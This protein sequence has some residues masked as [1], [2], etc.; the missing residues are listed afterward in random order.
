MIK[1]LS[2]LRFIFISLIFLHHIP[3]Y[4]GGGTLGVAFFF[5][6]GGFSLT[7]GYFKIVSDRSF[8]FCTYIN[9]RLT[10]FYPLHWLCLIVAIVRSFIGPHCMKFSFFALLPNALLLQ[11]WFPSGE[12]YN[13]YNA[14]SWYLS[15]TV[16]F[17]LI[18][19][20]ILKLIINTTTKQKIFSFIIIVLIYIVLTLV[21]PTDYYIFY[22]F[23]IVR[24]FDFLIGIYLAVTLLS[25]N[26]NYEKS[27]KNF[28]LKYSLMLNF[29]IFIFFITLILISIYSKPSIKIYS[30]I[31]WLPISTLIFLVTLKSKNGP[32]IKIL[33]LPL[34]VKLG[35]SSFSFY[36]IHQL[37]ISIGTMVFRYLNISQL[38]ITVPFVF[39]ITAILSVYCETYF[40]KPTAK[41]LT[42]RI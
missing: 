6:L 23:P 5:M 28:A 8:S 39:I 21:M 12:I 30:A 37:C 42:K 22:I 7:I 38:Y 31:Y 33:K 2:S 34:L 19:P 36:M 29:F 16:F 24:L 41:C 4:N 3:L 40:V 14:I 10:K 11:S 18:F 13:S 26:I 27:I 15:D 32:G 1:E 17:A 35:E 20:F 25:L 9:K